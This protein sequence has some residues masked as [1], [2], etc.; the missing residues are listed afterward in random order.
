MPRTC[1]GG[2]VEVVAIRVLSVS[3]DRAVR[4]YTDSVEIAREA[5]GETKDRG[6]ALL[7]ADAGQRRLTTSK[8]ESRELC[9]AK[10]EP[11]DDKLV[12]GGQV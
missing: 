7:V 6:V 9:S 4:K 3:E 11:A 8:V 2:I 10:S 1:R 12:L 5:V